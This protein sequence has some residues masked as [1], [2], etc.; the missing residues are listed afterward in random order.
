MVEYPLEAS[1]LTN[2]AIG[3]PPLVTAAVG[4]LVV[5]Y[6]IWNIKQ[7]PGI[8][9]HSHTT[10]TLWLLWQPPHGVHALVELTV[11]CMV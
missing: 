10:S 3:L 11:V 1:D 4:F 6:L 5:F 9:S 8:P 7:S 2:V